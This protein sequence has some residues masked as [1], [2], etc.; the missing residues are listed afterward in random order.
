MEAAAARREAE[1]SFAAR[2]KPV[3]LALTEEHMSCVT[4]KEAFAGST[5]GRIL[6]L[7]LANRDENKGRLEV[8]YAQ[9]GDRCVDTRCVGFVQ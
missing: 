9:E 1:I 8:I 5:R 4:G 3:E 6:M 2:D 7:Y